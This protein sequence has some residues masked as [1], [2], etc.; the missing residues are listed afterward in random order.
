MNRHVK[1]MVATM[2]IAT[3]VMSIPAFAGQNTVKASKLVAIPSTASTTAIKAMDL[4]PATEFDMGGE[5]DFEDLE[6]FE[7]MDNVNL[8]MDLTE[9]IPAKA[10]ATEKTTMTKLAG[11]AEKLWKA[12]KIDEAIAKEDAFFKILSKIEFQA[13][14][15]EPKVSFDDFYKDLGLTPDQVKTLKPLY[16]ATEKARLSGNYEAYEKA[17]D[18]L[19]KAEEPIF[20]NMIMATEIDGEAMELDFEPLTFEDLAKEFKMTAD[21]QKQLK[22]LYEKMIAAEKGTDEKAMTAASDAFWNKA[23]KILDLKGADWTMNFDDLMKDV[24]VTP[25]Q[26]TELKAL[27][28]K[29]TAAEKTKDMDKIMEADQAFWTLFDKYVK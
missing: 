17:L 11:E 16:E 8:V 24:K 10:S 9:L 14:K 2:A 22:P 6:G 21:Q 5:W 7:D 23:E 28:D 25:A 18:A 13:F 4:T 29:I 27:F 12:E 3:L 26:K 15:S 20:S 1:K 19:F